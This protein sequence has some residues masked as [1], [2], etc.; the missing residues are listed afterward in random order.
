MK[1]RL[2]GYPDEFDVELTAIGGRSV[3]VRINGNEEIVAAIEP[4]FATSGIVW[5]GR[6][7]ARVFSTRQHGSIWVAAG[8]AQFE[9]IPVE[10]RSARRMHG[11][12]IP[13]ITAPMPG[14]VVKLPVTE[15]QQVE[16]GDVLVVLEAMKMETALYAES[17]AVVKQIRADVGQM[18]DH[19][20]VLLLLSPVPPPSSSGA[21]SPAH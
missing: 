5:I 2:A 3:R 7:A 10:A 14:K 13:E 8:P 17:A 19:G 1:F 12:A 11:L 9:F 20:T 18:V 15:G 16:A 4:A 6:R 21:A